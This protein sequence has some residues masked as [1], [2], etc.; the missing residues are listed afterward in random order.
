M[1]SDEKLVR[2]PNKKWQ[3]K[4]KKKNKEEEQEE[5]KNKEKEDKLIGKDSISSS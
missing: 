2:G 4:K 5:K 3:K 1:N